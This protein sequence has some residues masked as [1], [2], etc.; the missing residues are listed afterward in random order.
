MFLVSSRWV[1]YEAGWFIDD[2]ERFILKQN[3]QRNVFRLRLG[4]TG[5]GPMNFHRFSGTRGVR[6]LDGFAIHADMALFNQPLHGATRNGGKFFPQEGVEPQIHLRMFDGEMF[7]AG[8]HEELSVEGLGEFSFFQV[9]IKMSATPVQMA[10][11]AI[12]N[13]GKPHSPPPRRGR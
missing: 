7:R 12:L 6:G 2:Q 11:S 1:N 5:F 9:M 8:A 10:E 4:G 3:I 13:A